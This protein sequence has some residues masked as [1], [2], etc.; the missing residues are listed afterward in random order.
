MQ[1]RSAGLCGCVARGLGAPFCV[2]I[3]KV[4]APAPD[5]GQA[6]VS[7]DTGGF[8]SASLLTQHSLESEH[9]C[10]V[11]LKGFQH[12]QPLA[13]APGLLRRGTCHT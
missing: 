3:G 9:M 10:A 4:S 8:P 6:V 7:R 5:T 2:L 1:G 12:R 11:S 13:L